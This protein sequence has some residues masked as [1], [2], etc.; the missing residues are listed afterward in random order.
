MDETVD[1]KM[2]AHSSGENV[3]TLELTDGEYTLL[4]ENACSKV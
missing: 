1:L 4:F 3:V 2:Q